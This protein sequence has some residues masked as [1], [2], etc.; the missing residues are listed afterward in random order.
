LRIDKGSAH[1]LLACLIRER[2]VEQRPTD[3]RYLL[4]PLVWELGLS[5]PG[6]FESRDS[7]RERLAAVARRFGGLAFLMVRSGKSAFAPCALVM[8]ICV[9]CRSMSA[10]GDR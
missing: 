7:C 8:R 9:L 3:R 1:R 2:L 5:V 6:H 4:G 10:R